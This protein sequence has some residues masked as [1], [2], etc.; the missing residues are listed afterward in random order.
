MEMSSAGH[1]GNLRGRLT[2]AITNILGCIPR[3][4][5][6]LGSGEIRPPNKEEAATCQPRLLELMTLASPQRI[7][8]LGK[9]AQRFFPKPKQLINTK[10]PRWDGV[11]HFLTHPSAIVRLESEAP[12]QA[13]L[14]EKKF[15]LNLSSVIRTLK[16]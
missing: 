16:Q 7:V 13:S 12:M 15:I 14:L 2:Y 4:P 8:L 6:D 1:V 5:D 10:L 11:A 3:H 9:I